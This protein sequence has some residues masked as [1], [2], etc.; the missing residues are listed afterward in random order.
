MERKV[1]LNLDE[2]FT[3]LFENLMAAYLQCAEG[4]GQERHGNGKHFTNQP[5]FKLNEL[6]GDGFNAGQVAKKLQEACTMANNG[7]Y[8]R[9][10]REAL[11]AII[12]CAS[13]A[14]KWDRLE[15]NYRAETL[16]KVD[17]K[18]GGPL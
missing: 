10:H 7:E 2:N 17:P 1:E 6:F 15:R 13:L 5:I 14:V 4:K 12:Y 9:A 8:A 16:L 18:T 3:E 11:G